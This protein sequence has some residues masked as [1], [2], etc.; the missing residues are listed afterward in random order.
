MKQ[1]FFFI[2][3]QKIY[4]G[5]VQISISQRVVTG[6]YRGDFFQVGGFSFYIKSKL[7]SEIFDDKK[8]L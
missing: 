4:I 6:K 8:G 5:S 2:K 7:K 1:G 3:I